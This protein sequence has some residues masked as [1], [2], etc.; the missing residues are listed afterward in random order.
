MSLLNYPV[1]CVISTLEHNKGET[2]GMV[3]YVYYIKRRNS[4]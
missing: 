1:S 2:D 3:K 4:L